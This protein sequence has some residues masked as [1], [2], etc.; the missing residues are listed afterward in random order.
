MAETKLIS[1]P[2]L[3][4]KVFGRVESQAKKSGK[5]GDFFVTLLK[6]P[7]PDSFSSPGTFEIRSKQ[8]LGSRGSEIEVLCDLRGYSRS[9]KDKDGVT[10]QTAEAVLQ[11]V[12]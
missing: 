1:S 3:Q 5:G 6:T 7:A 2:L 10:V 4:V 8:P 9:Y 11:A 12:A